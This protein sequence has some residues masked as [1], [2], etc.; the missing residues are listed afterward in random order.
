MD[1]FE[2]GQRALLIDH[3]QRRYLITLKAGETFHFHRGSIAHDDI[4]GTAEGRKIQT[5]NGDHL[6]LLRP[7]LSDFVLKMPRGAQVIYPKDLAMLTTLC[8]IHPGAKVFEA[9]TGSGALTIALLRA[10]GDEGEVHSFDSREEHA[11]V[12]KSNI[13]AFYGKAENLTIEVVDVYR[14]IPRDDASLDRAILDL[15]EPWNAIDNLTR[16]LRPGA[17]LATYVP[18]ILQVHRLTEDLAGRRE[19]TGTS[20]VEVLVRSWHVEGQ[21]VRPDHRM[22]AHTGF[23]TTARLLSQS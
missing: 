2:A 12:A 4:I 13:E 11:D 17:I 8:D 20:T 1:V 14:D 7:T 6:I 15:A 23:L 3:K 9:G 5:P 21:S 19:W 10:V 16:V 18:T 22:V